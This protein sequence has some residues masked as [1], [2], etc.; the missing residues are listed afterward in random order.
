MNPHNE[1]GVAKISRDN[2]GN[3]VSDVYHVTSSIANLSDF[4]SLSWVGS[5]WVGCKR[6]G[7][8][9][10]EEGIEEK[11]KRSRRKRK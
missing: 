3:G 2:G 5:W 7:E 9:G 6:E 10:R 11:R 1:G 4:W 8:S